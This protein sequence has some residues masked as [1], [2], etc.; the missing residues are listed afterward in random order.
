MRISEL[1]IAVIIALGLSFLLFGCSDPTTPEISPAPPLDQMPLSLAQPLFSAGYELV[2]YYELDAD[3]DGVVEVLA[4][5]TLKSPITETSLG[6]SRVLLFGQYGGRWSLAGN[7]QMDG[8]NAR[9]ELRELTGD[10]FPELIVFTEE[11]DNQL[12]DFV[13]PL[14]YTDHLTVFTYTP[15]PYLADLGTFSSSL[16]GVMRPRSTVE[17][18][19]GQTA[20]Q[21]IHDLPPVGSPLLWPFRVETFTWDGQDFASVQVQEQHRISPIVLWLVRRNAPWG[22]GLLILGGVLSVC[23]TVVARRSRLQER[24]M[25]LILVL[26]FIVGGIAVGLAQKWL[27]VPALVLTGLMGL[28]IGWQVTRRL[29]ASKT[30]DGA[31]DGE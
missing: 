6:D 2:G 4:V 23:L 1:R 16:S 3:S 20:I 10:G 30:G 29:C 21:T 22:A 18:W 11:V 25:I 8:I 9:A 5:V 14:R 15:G 27:C 28:G 13:T 17:K 31:E 26:L 24:W 12:G 19:E 7:Q